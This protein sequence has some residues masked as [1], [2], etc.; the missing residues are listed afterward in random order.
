MTAA[1]RFGGMMEKA[2]TEMAAGEW[3]MAAA[4]DAQGGN[5]NFDF[6]EYVI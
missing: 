4:E 5:K 6:H 2:K 1:T 3:V